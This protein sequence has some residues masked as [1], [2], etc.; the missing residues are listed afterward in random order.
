[1]TGRLLFFL[2]LALAFFMGCDG[3]T[4]PSGLD[5]STFPDLPYA[6]GIRLTRV[7]ANQGVGIP[8]FQGGQWVPLAERNARLIEDRQTLIWG[9]WE[10]DKKWKPRVIR[11]ELKVV[12]PDGESETLTEEIF[13]GKGTST[14]GSRDLSISWELSP[15]LAAHGSTFQIYLLE[16]DGKGKGSIPLP[17][18][19]Y[20]LTPEPIGFEDSHQ[21]IRVTVVPVQHEYPGSC[22][23]VPELSTSDVET[24]GEL[25]HRR[26]PTQRV[27]MTLREPFLWTE[28]LDSYTGLLAAL[29]QL[30]FEDNA[31]PAQYYAG[32]VH[33]CVRTGGQ[34]IDRPDFPTK[35]N[36]W[37]RTIVS[38][39]RGSAPLTS[40]TFVHEMGHAQGRRHVRCTGKEGSPDPDYPYPN[41]NIGVWG[42][43]IV[44]PDAT[45][46]WLSGKTY[47]PQ[48]TYDFMG[49][50][51]GSHHVSDYGWELVYPFIEEISSWEIPGQP[52]PGP[53]QF[54][55]DG[56]S[57]LIGAVE[58]DGDEHWFT[59]PGSA[60]A[61]SPTPGYYA[62]FS[63][64]GG[65]LRVPVSARVQSGSGVTNIVVELPLPLDKVSEITLLAPEKRTV[66][67]LQAVRRHGG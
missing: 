67:D 4:D 42:Y 41:G 10:V 11:A 38:A 53:P 31:N 49:Y 46:P 12:L 45:M 37:T 17:P 22:S 57:L 15:E 13:V 43:N 50:C 58:P 54:P 65:T 32:L 52:S 20:P 14:F 35:E 40:S 3:G 66:V 62:E 16:L 29:S 7:L 44:L 8:I 61:R 33:H 56:G 34:A 5:D 48:T 30:R 24:L 59:L 63:T 25:L 1:M 60:G 23:D 26:S 47:N 36:G 18:P 9:V 2:P 21:V 51:T 28:S 55:I 64:A 39:W 6:K 19:I 27:V